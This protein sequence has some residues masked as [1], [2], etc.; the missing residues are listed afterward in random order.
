MLMQANSNCA[1][2]VRPP[3]GPL[4]ARSAP[5]CRVLEHFNYRGNPNVTPNVARKKP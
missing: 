2:Q 5:R 3:F 4:Q 1:H